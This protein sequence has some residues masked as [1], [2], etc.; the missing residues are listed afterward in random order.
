[1]KIQVRNLSVR[2][3]GAATAA[4]QDISLTVPPGTLFAVLGPNGSGK[5]TLAR[6]ILGAVPPESGEILLDDAPLG[7]LSRRTMARAVGAVA[8]SEPLPF[9]MTARELVAMGRYA[10]LGPLASEGDADREAIQ[11]ALERCDVQELAERRVQTLSGGELQRVRIARA[12][13]QQ[14]RALVLDEPTSSL[15]IRHEMAIMELLHGSAEC[16]ITVVLITHHLDLASRFADRILLLSEGRVAAEGPPGEVL[17]PEVLRR[18]YRW[19]VVVEL[20]G[21]TGS[22]RV[23]P[24]RPTDPPHAPGSTAVHTPDDDS[25]LDAG[26]S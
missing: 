20:D 18:V 23:V 7:T 11:A 19:P 5:S 24:V 10:H 14:P 12:L 6:T 17:D 2:Y 21:L 25:G 16:G 13:A 8:Q 9:P 22:P 26:G 4:L 1:V 3:P 15:D